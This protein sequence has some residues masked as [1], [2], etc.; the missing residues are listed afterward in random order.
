MTDRIAHRPVLCPRRPQPSRVFLATLAGLVLSAPH[1]TAQSRYSPLVTIGVGVVPDRDG[2]D[3]RHASVAASLAVFR[4]LGSQVDLGLE[5]GYQRF[6]TG[7]REE[8]IGFC[9]TLPVG[10]CVGQVTAT[11]RSRGDLWFVGPTLRVRVV[12]QGAVRPFLLLGLGRYGSG[13]HTSVTFRD[14]RGVTVPDPESFAYEGDFD[15]LGVNAGIGIEGGRLGRLRWTVGARAHGALGGLDGE[16][17]SV[18]SYTLTAG[19]TLP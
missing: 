7:P 18:T 15:G 16:F 4:R 2:S 6:G 13:E 10:A 3:E 14:D 5:A 9:P 1:L 8:L 11:R 19:V 12:R 17:G